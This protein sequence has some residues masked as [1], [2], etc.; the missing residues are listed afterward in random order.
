MDLLRIGGN[1]DFGKEATLLSVL[2]IRA[3]TPDILQMKVDEVH[4]RTWLLCLSGATKQRW[5]RTKERLPS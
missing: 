2:D 1:S 3:A 4:C 5:C